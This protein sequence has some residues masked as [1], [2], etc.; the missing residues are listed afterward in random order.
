[1]GYRRKNK[2]TIVNMGLK[3]FCK[4]K[5]N[6]GGEVDFRILQEGVDVLLPFMKHSSRVIEVPK[7]L[8]LKFTDSPLLTFDEIRETYK[9]DRFEKV[10]L[11]SAIMTFLQPESG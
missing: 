6:Q 9:V 1:M 11:G 10:K 4:N 7:E 8:F 2:L 3:I 5:G